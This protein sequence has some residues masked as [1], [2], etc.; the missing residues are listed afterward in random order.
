MDGT[1][2]AGIRKRRWISLCWL[3]AA[4][5]LPGGCLQDA[6]D[7]CFTFDNANDP[8]ASS[9]CVG[10]EPADTGTGSSSLTIVH[11]ATINEVVV[12]ANTGLADQDMTSWTLEN[13]VSGTDTFTFPGFTLLEGTSVRVHSISGLD[14][15]DDL[16]WDGGDH[17]DTLDSIV[18]KD[19]SGNT[20]DT[21]GDGEVC[22]DKGD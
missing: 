11:V 18:L 12:I 13:E 14:D 15:A 8:Q 2:S 16:Y 1:G 19:D 3:C 22:W 4:L 20:I 7:Q 21:C 9:A 10:G 17:W 5:L 6:E